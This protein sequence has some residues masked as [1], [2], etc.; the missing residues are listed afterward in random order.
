MYQQSEKFITSHRSR[1]KRANDYISKSPE[2]I[3]I[4]DRE[5]LVEFYLLEDIERLYEYRLAE[6]QKKHVQTR[7][8]EMAR[9][10][11]ISMFSA[12]VQLFKSAAE[13]AWGEITSGNYRAV[14][15]SIPEHALMVAA[16]NIKN[17]SKLRY[18]A[19]KMLRS[20]S[21]EAMAMVETNIAFEEDLDS[22]EDHEANVQKMKGLPSLADINEIIRAAEIAIPDDSSSAKSRIR[23]NIG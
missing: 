21:E 19:V 18:L 8:G 4:F 11:N 17:L 6:E 14:W 22:I 23:P 13:V 2:R 15:S 1:V 9:S 16:P 20:L 12:I 10:R 5:A 3:S 7:A